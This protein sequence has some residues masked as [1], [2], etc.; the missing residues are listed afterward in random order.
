MCDY[1]H[2]LK[3]HNALTNVQHGF[4]EN[5]STETARHSFIQSVQE[6]LERHLHV[7]GIFL[8]MSK[9]YDVINHNML[10]DKLDSYGV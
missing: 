8:D 4:M 7:V 6:A 10:L 2:F 3:K 5:K 1:S 9:A